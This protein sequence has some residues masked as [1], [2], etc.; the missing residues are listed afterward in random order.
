MTQAGQAGGLQEINY[1]LINAAP[2]ADL[3]LITLGL[4]SAL[5]QKDCKIAIDI[6]IIIISTIII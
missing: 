4:S 1:K 3:Y 6:I 2:Y 5:V